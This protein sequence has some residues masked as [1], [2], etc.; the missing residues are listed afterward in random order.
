[1]PVRIG[2]LVI[3]DSV[4]DPSA[5]GELSSIVAAQEQYGIAVAAG[6]LGE[7]APVG[8]G[9]WDSG[10]YDWSHFDKAEAG[11]EFFPHVERAATPRWFGA[12]LAIEVDQ[13]TA[14]V[15][16]ERCEVRER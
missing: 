9:A 8:T 3:G 12:T 5:G 7:L 6:F 1:M 14:E 2:A 16:H 13:R 4:A 11:H 10:N 15:G